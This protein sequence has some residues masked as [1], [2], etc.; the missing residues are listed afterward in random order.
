MLRKEQPYV[1]SF[2]EEERSFLHQYVT[3][4]DQPIFA[5]IN[6]PE[7]VKG[8]LFA[9]YSRSSKSLRRLLLD[10]F[11]TDL[12]GQRFFQ[13]VGQM[14]AE[15]LYQRVF[16]EYGDDSIAQLGAVHIACEGISNIVTKHLERGRLMSYLE[17]STRYIPYTDKPGGHWKYHVP[18]GLSSVEMRTY[19]TIIDS[20]FEDYASFIPKVEAYL[21]AE[22]KDT[23]DAAG[24]AFRRAVRAK[25]LDLL[26]GL[27]P[28]ATR[29]NVGV[30]G[31]GQAYEYL[32]MRMLSSGNEEAAWVAHLIL[33]EL[34]HVIPS[35]VARIPRPDRGG[36]WVK[37]LEE[38]RRAV[39]SLA[40]R[41]TQ[42]IAPHGCIDEV[43]LVDFDPEGEVKVVA[44][45]LYA[46]ST[47]SDSQLLEIARQMTISE[48]ASVLQ[49]YV[50][51]RVNRRHRPGRAFERT[52]YRFDILGEYGAF[53][54]LQRHRMMTLDWQVF[55]PAHGYETP[56]AVEEAGLGPQWHA[57][58][59]RAAD[60]HNMLSQRHS[61][62]IAAYAVPMAYRVRYYMEMNAREA[63]H[64]MELR[65][66]PQGH[67][68]YRRIAQRM[69]TLIAETAGHRAIAD[70]MRFV[71]H[72]EAPLER[73]RAERA[74][75][76]R[77]RQ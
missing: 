9:R 24:P 22:H 21:L 12:Q 61:L 33:Q 44:A 16:S 49:T 13:H 76:E 73:L 45:A 23:E 41:L 55:T 25:A 6:L 46:Q 42:G 60:L 47:I 67:T 57:A 4:V 26:R 1:E 7:V 19:C 65:S 37:Y 35:F 3:N 70:T 28:A 74:A 68:N 40:Q 71:D 77:R 69:H 2:T 75:E 34:E 48:R 11:R 54:D 29:S 15:A 32:I 50:G 66:A 51:T 58:M 62:N 72:T 64:V 56:Q 27:L 43:S 20:L 10:E 59:E 53:R 52:S 17:Q 39:E 8:A 31:S 30:F 18:E 36:E 38:S 63:M 5:L 14:R